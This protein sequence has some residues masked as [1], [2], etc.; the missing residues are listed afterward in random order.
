MSSLGVNFDIHDAFGNP[1]HPFLSQYHLSTEMGSADATFYQKLKSLFFNIVFRI[2]FELEVVSTTDI[3]IKKYFGE[4][5]PSIKEIYS[6]LSLL[7]TCSNPILEN[8]RPLVPT[9]VTMEFVHMVESQPLPIVRYF[10]IYI[11]HDTVLHEFDDIQLSGY[12]G[13]YRF[14][15]KWF[16]IF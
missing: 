5:M 9:V 3:T 13:V 14:F 12:T 6:R 2:H 7:L 10:I 16:R 4:N 15:R 8:V 11:I 1:T